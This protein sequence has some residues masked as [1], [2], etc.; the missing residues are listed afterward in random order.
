MLKKILGLTI[1]IGSLNADTYSLVIDV[2]NLKANGKN[3]DVA[4]GDPD[5]L[6]KIDGELQPMFESCKNAYRCVMEFESDASEWY[7]EVY[8]K[9][10]LAND[11][12]GR[13]NCSVGDTCEFDGVK[14]KI[15]K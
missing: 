5:I 10:A 11:I 1:L 3:W 9:D 13:G 6:L 7:I 2:P 8:D 12:I 14:M 4:G 15:T